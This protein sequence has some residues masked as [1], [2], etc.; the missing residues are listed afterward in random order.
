MV[1]FDIVH[2][3]EV[4]SVSD[5]VA[6]VLDVRRDAGEREL[7][8]R[9]HSDAGFRLIPSIA[10]PQS[11]AGRVATLT[12]RQEARLL[13]RFRRR[14]C[15][16]VGEAMTA[17]QAIFLARHHGL[18][19]RLLDWTAHALFALHFACTRDAGSGGRDA[20]V[21]AMLRRE[22]SHDVDA[23]DLKEVRDEAGLFG[24]HFR[25]RDKS[26][27][28]PHPSDT[29][30]VKIVHPLHDSSRLS[31]QEAAF[32]LHADPWT[33]LEELAGREFS[34]TNLDVER[35]LRWIVPR[36]QKLRIT[37]ELYGLGISHHLVYPDLD[38]IAR[39]LL[40]AEL[41]RAEEEPEGPA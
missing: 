10:R 21:W 7:W 32:T 40:H 4:A 8:Y 30:A 22:D 5:F 39:S 35:L 3:A 38:G 31:A 33:D 41:L 24:L 2:V 27:P 13:H 17:G 18:P 15:T 12:S 20:A 28:P 25:R 14:A 23:F 19:T 1:R 36:Q 6:S 29:H 16:H 26:E 11:F 34:E 37:R 9:G